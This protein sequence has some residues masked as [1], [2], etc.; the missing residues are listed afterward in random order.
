MQDKDY[1]KISK[2]QDPNFDDLPIKS[3]EINEAP[4]K[5]IFCNKTKANRGS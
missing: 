3:S 5:S 4:I 1:Y 2:E